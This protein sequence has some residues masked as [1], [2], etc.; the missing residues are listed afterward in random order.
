M[1]KII[2]MF[3]LFILIISCTACGELIAPVDSNKT[4]IKIS[5]YNGGFGVDWI[6][7]AASDFNS[8]N[9][10]YKIVIVDNKYGVGYLESDMASTAA[11]ADAYYTCEPNIKKLINKNLVVDLTDIYETKVDGE[12]GVTIKDKIKN[13]DIFSN[14]LS[15][16]GKEGIYGLPLADALIGLVFDY[17]LFVEKG[18]LL[19]DTDGTLKA[20]KDGI[21][22]TYDDGQ[23]ITE[24][25]WEIM[26]NMINVNASP[27]IWTGEFPTYTD[28][29]L[30]AMLA[31]YE[32]LDNYKLM[33]TFNGTYV[34]PSDGAETV[35]TPETGY[36]VY[37]S[38]GY[39]K[40]FS[41][42]KKYFGNQNYLHPSATNR[43]TS[44]RGAQ[45]KFILG[46]RNVAEN[47]LSAMLV[48]GTW[49]ENEAKVMFNALKNEGE[50]ERGYGQREYRYMLL[51]NLT[52]QN[53]LIGNS[54]GSVLA[55]RDNGVI[56]VRK[57]NDIN[58]IRVAKE[59]VAFTCKDE[60]LR[61]YTV[62][63]NSPRPFIYDL[64]DED[65]NKM[66]PFGRNIW[67]MYQDTDNIG[68]IRP[69]VDELLSPIFY[70]TD[71]PSMFVSKLGGANVF[72]PIV[73]LE[74]NSVADYI[75]GIKEINN[76]VTWA[77]H[78]EDCQDLL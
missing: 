30:Y 2:S 74:R 47:P 5:V 62:A 69:Y 11:I 42:L 34:R 7:K 27:F 14:I 25:E 19:T 3:I 68:I 35:I 31:Q 28:Q 4:E 45:D 49:W 64:I 6:N 77:K 20:G 57:Q 48:D 41:F 33:N 55:C 66:T 67:N 51:P 61:E 32:G 17:T 21:K 46:Y 13:Y 56:V 54:A 76:T 22:G 26:L 37:D 18:W 40:A 43:Y 63:T 50:P 1:K 23:P 29:I 39:N 75:A 10:K 78:I 52:G 16:N 12:N 15:A 9:E 72:T 53:G 36:K 24:A 73:G 44:H 8:T 71:K 70:N 60:Y 58:K 38:E 59:F 65:L